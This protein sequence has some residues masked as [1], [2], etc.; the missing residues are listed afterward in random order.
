MIILSLSGFSQ[1]CKGKNCLNFSMEGDFVSLC[2]V[3]SDIL[4]G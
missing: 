1:M 4:I 3:F 2:C